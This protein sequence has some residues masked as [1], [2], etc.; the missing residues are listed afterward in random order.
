MQFKPRIV[1][2]VIAIVVHQGP[3][4]AQDFLWRPESITAA[5]LQDNE[6]LRIGQYLELRQSLHEGE[7]SWTMMKLDLPD[8]WKVEGI[9]T[10]HEAVILKTADGETYRLDRENITKLDWALLDGG[11]KSDAEV[12]RLW[13]E[14]ALVE[15]KRATQRR[16]SD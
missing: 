14:H 16:R 11:L 5:V 8:T 10:S 1:W 6:F 13:R 7:V 4:L 9:R 3:T 2:L 15:G 12:L